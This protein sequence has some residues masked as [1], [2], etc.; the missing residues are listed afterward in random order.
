MAKTYLLYVGAL[1][2]LLRVLTTLGDVYTEES[3]SVS[4]INFESIL[5]LY[6]LFGLP[7]AATAEKGRTRPVMVIV[8]IG[9]LLPGAGTM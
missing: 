9:M 3:H 7:G 1:C 5:A 4:T 8:A 2:G 6:P